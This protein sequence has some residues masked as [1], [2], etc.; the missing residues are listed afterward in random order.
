MTQPTAIA[1]M[2][3]SGTSM[4]A[5]L[6]HRAGMYLGDESDLI[7][8]SPENPD[9]YFEH[10]EFVDLNEALLHELGGGWDCPVVLPSDWQGL[11]SLEPLRSRAAQL[12]E[13]FDGHESWGWKDPRTSLVLPFWRALAPDT[14]VVLCL[15]HPLEV[16][17]SLRRR[18]MSSYSLSLTLWETYNRRV[19]ETTDPDSRIITHYESYFEDP[20]RQ[21]ARLSE[22][23]GVRPSKRAVTRATA[24]VKAANRHFRF[25]AEDLR[26]AGAA[27]DLLDLYAYLVDEAEGSPRGLEYTART[28]RH[29][30]GARSLW[31]TVRARDT[32]GRRTAGPSEATRIDRNAMGAEV[33]RRDLR[34]LRGTL[35]ERDRTVATLEHELAES[36]SAL[37]RSPAEAEASTRVLNQLGGT[38]GRMVELFERLQ[39]QLDRRGNELQSTLHELHAYQTGVRAL[40]AADGS[41]HAYRQDV[42]RLREKVHECVPQHATVLVASHG[43]TELVKLYGREAWHFPRLADGAYAGYH[44]SNGTAAVVH[45]EAMHA[46]GA[47]YFVIPA[48]MSW[49]LDHYAELRQY[50][51][52]HCRLVHRQDDTCHIYSLD[53]PPTGGHA[54][55]TAAFRQLVAE[56]HARFDRDPFVLDW[57]TGRELASLAPDLKVFSPPGD[58]LSLDYLD[59]TVDVVVVASSDPDRLSESKRVASSATLV[60][61]DDGPRSGARVYGRRPPEVAWLDSD[62]SALPSASIVVPCY[63]GLQHTR[64]CLETLLRTVT[65]ALDC[66]VVVVDDDSRDG[67][68]EYLAH[69]AH[70]D[71]R[72]MV[73]RNPSN[74]G[75]LAS[76]NRGGAAA[77]GDI[78]IFLNNDTILLSRWITALLRTFRRF[79]DAGVVGGKLL[80]PDG[81]IQEAGG[82]VFRDGSAAKFGAFDPD[83]TLSLYN[84]VRDVDYCSGALLATP[85]ALFEQLDGFDPS[86]GPGYYEDTDY[87]FR[88]RESGLRVL[89]QPASTIIHLEGATAGRDVSVG[90]KNHQVLNHQRFVT[91]WEEVLSASPERPPE[92]FDFLTLYELAGATHGATR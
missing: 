15:R 22:F 3:R 4:V 81:R 82:V 42:D 2:H 23:A 18:G 41:K 87:C 62:T 89:Y 69:L 43:D 84:F 10:A 35:K 76:V 29:R 44:P 68:R 67:T 49:W 17:L 38:Q 8:A 48:A 30:R 31:R 78:L 56:F 60:L 20:A 80:Y 74:L 19:V 11:K 16:A 53:E 54:T 36:R 85:R 45:L 1:G 26:D 55:E 91:R 33:L 24:T 65:P 37:E 34:E 92:P 25:T 58:E 71:E 52:S 90:M 72:V 59:S 63:D 51:E 73:I 64:V 14:Q 7:P 77:S 79:D 57:G 47:N 6:L 13:A 5:H 12:I 39:A 86:Y 70:T 21:L 88:A 46:L 83:P 9:G 66:E 27:P 61:D 32:P 28:A 50:L 75:Y 40:P